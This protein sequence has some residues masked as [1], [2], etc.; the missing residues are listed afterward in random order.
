MQVKSANSIISIQSSL[1]FLGAGAADLSF[2]LLLFTGTYA[3]QLA[4]FTIVGKHRVSLL[5]MMLNMTLSH[6]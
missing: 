6:F 1:T 5:A 4:Q 3:D 2:C